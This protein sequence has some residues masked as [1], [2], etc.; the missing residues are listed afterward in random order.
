MRFEITLS[1][2]AVASNSGVSQGLDV[3][4][5]VKYNFLI[6]EMNTSRPIAIVAPLCF[7]LLISKIA[8]VSYLELSGELAKLLVKSNLWP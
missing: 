8:L 1:F 7:Y 5:G 3:N 2:E 4:V 6:F